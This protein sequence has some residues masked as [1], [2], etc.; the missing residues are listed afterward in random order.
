MSEFDSKKEEKVQKIYEGINF[1]VTRVEKPVTLIYELENLA[2]KTVN[3]MLD[4]RQSENLVSEVYGENLIF[5]VLL[6]PCSGRREICRL[7]LKDLGQKGSAK[8]KKTWKIENPT[9]EFINDYMEQHNSKLRSYLQIA[10]ELELDNDAASVKELT[11]TCLQNN[12][13]FLDAFFPP[14]DTS[15]YRTDSGEVKRNGPVATWRYAKYV[16]KSTA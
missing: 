16:L 9:E 3:F 11:A 8:C 15:L 7:V 12:I 1:Y 4:L 14:D 10:L 2:F 6:L 5:E 13:H